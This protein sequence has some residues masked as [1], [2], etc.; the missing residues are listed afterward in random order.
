MRTIAKITKVELRLLFC[1][2]IAWLIIII[3]GIQTSIAFCNLFGN[4]VE[5]QPLGM[6]LFSVTK[7]LFADRFGL[8]SQVQ[9]YLYLYIP[10]LTMGVMSRERS[11]G[12]IRLL[13][14]SPVTNRQIILGKFVGLSVFALALLGVL[15]VYA[16]FC[17]FVVKDFDFI[18]LISAF[19]G[20]YLLTLSY[21][22]IG[23]FMST[24]TSYQ[25][26]AAM[27][28]LATLTLLNLV[29]T[30]GQKIAFVRDITYWI[31]IQGRADE[32]MKG[33][34][35]SEDVLYFLLVSAAFL[36]FAILKLNFERKKAPLKTRILHY[37][38]VCLATVFLGYLSSRPILKCYWDATCTKENSLLPNGQ[39]VMKQMDGGLTVTTYVNLLDE[40]F[41]YGLPAN[42]NE[43]IRRFRDHIRFKPTMKMKYVYYYDKTENESLEKRFPGMSDEQKAKELAEGMELNLEKFLTPTQIREKIDLSSEGN[44]FIR[45]LE[46]SNG[47]N[48]VL[49]AYDG[50]SPMPGEG[51]ITAAMK[52]LVRKPIQIAFLTGHG[53]RAIDRKADRDYF[54]FAQDITDRKSLVN[55]GFDCRKIN[56]QYD[57]LLADS[58]DILVIA[59]VKTPLDTMELAAIHRFM[60]AGGSLLIAAEPGRQA[61]MNPIVAPL[62]ITFKTGQV[63]VDSTDFKQNIV[64][65]RITPDCAR[66]A[67]MLQWMRRWNYRVS[68]PDAVGI[69]INNLTDSIAVVLA[70][71]SVN[72]W[73]E[74]RTVVFDDLR[75]KRAV[76]E[77]EESNI[78][79]L[80]LIRQQNGKP[81]RMLIMG[82][83]DFLSNGESNNYRQG[84]LI[85]NDLFIKEMMM[86]LTDHEF[87]IDDRRP[88]SP[89]DAIYVSV[90]SIPAVKTAI[91][92]GLTFLLL[93][94]GLIINIV[95]KVK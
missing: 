49:R 51:E 33:L 2:P 54:R 35:C 21:S 12:S 31:S 82:D 30:V 43:D 75:I 8:F 65:G 6:S 67:R 61:A 25:V 26:V 46:R 87:P 88:R 81:Q 27:T 57:S 4:M 11:S 44:R 79:G 23:L 14:S 50:A 13:F 40:C 74:L 78:L 53:E 36:A 32:M 5:G 84:V 9:Q 56:L 89:D 47:Q 17:C 28:T 63:V 10:L 58:V 95:R 80:Q 76:D 92:G 69:E 86:W 94:I 48:S 66:Q 83:A 62:G 77:P 34:L 41:T 59:D 37:A 3:F 93:C 70:T 22:A 71:D 91:I 73:N 18:A 45:I 19:A 24:L 29:G 42:R 60:E 16:V 38:G 1:S 52:R 20:I 7:R 64:F 68:M 72:S 55:N 85:D 15:L 90:E 39:Q